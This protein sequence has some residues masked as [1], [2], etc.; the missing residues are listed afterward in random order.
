M[1]L[2]VLEPPKPHIKQ[3]KIVHQTNKKWPFLSKRIIAIAYNQ[4]NRAVAA[5]EARDRQ[6]QSVAEPGAQPQ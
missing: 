1:V 4:L 5:W 3:T 2:A 6:F